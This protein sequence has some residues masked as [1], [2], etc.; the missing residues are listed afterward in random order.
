MFKVGDRVQYVG[1]PDKNMMNLDYLGL[2]GEVERASL[3]DRCYVRWDARPKML[4]MHFNRNLVLIDETPA[5]PEDWM[6]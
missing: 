3:T 2:V 5:E 4:P 1:N 6:N